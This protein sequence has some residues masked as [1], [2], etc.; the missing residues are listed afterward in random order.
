M[1]PTP[2]DTPQDD[3][4]PRNIGAPATAALALVGCTRLSQ[5]PQF[6][7]AELLSLHGVGP[8]AIERLRAALA[9]R[10]WH[11]RRRGK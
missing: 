6:R 11:L 7:A 5:V 2:T 10:G 4:L 8:K 1:N 9:A 3:S